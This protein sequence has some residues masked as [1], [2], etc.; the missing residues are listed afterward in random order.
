MNTKVGIFVFFI[1]LLAF[2]Q[3][4]HPHRQG[5]ILYNN[6]CANCHMEDGSGLKGNIPPLAQSD[7]LS[8]YPEQVACIIRYGQKGEIEVNGKTYSTEMAA[9]PQLNKYEIANVINYIRH[10]WGNDLGFYQ[11]GAIEQDLENCEAAER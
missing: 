11:V 7:Y 2:A 4:E 5:E 6:F 10:S 1:S 9:I 3:C 8:K